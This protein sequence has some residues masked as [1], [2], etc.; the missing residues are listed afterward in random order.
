MR[1][2]S[3]WLF[4]GPSLAD[5]SCSPRFGAWSPLVGWLARFD[6]DDVLVLEVVLVVPLEHSSARLPRESLILSILE[7]CGRPADDAADGGVILVRSA[8]SCCWRWRKISPSRHMTGSISFMKCCWGPMI[9]YSAGTSVH[10]TFTHARTHTVRQDQLR[11]PVRAHHTLP[12][13]NSGLTY[14][15]GLHIRSHPITSAAVRRKCFMR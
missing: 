6:P 2:K 10:D 15:P 1:R 3:P 5:K 11:G 9:L 14:V 13:A 12:G 7:A 4:A 8:A